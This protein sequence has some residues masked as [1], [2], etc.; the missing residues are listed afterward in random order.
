[1]Q[2]CISVPHVGHNYALCCFCFV[3]I[4]SAVWVLLLQQCCF[5]LARCLVHS[6]VS[7]VQLLHAEQMQHAEGPLLLQPALQSPPCDTPWILH[8]WI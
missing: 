2:P 4:C 5:W 3:L 8:R 7:I 6:P 1:M